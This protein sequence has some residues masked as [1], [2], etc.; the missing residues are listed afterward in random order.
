MLRV[1]GKEMFPPVLIRAVA[2]KSLGL[3]QPDVAYMEFAFKFK[4]L[5]PI[6][7]GA[8]RQDLGLQRFCYLHIPP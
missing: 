7:P 1:W 5:L 6:T 8:P 4:S 3:A 2:D